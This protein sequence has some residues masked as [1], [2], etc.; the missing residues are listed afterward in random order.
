MSRIRVAVICDFI[1]EGWLS[2]D[3]IAEM[4]LRE[5]AAHHA[6]EIEATQVRPR[7]ARR[8][9]YGR[10]RALFN[11]D[12][13]CNR[14]F[15]YP[16]IVRRM[17]DDFDLFHVIDHSYAHLVS[18]L[19]PARAVVTCHDTDA[20]AVLRESAR[21]P[22]AP[23]LRAMARRTLAGMRQAAR[24]TCDSG[25]TRDA[26]TVA[27]LAPADRVT[28]VHNGVHPAFGPS[29]DPEA[30]AEAARLS[31]AAD[32]DATGDSIEVLHVG[33]TIARKRVDVVIRAIAELRT[34]FPRIRL[35]QAGGQFTREQQRMITGLGLARSTV[36]VPTM[37]VRVL[38][39]LYRR[40]AILAMPSESEGFGLPVA[41]AMAC[42]TPVLASDIAPLREVGGDAASYC[43]VGD[44]RAWALAISAMLRER[45]ESPASWE[46]RRQSGIDRA[47]QFTWHEFADRMAAIYRETAS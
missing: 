46:R 13:L 33:S 3:L 12:R 21:T 18:E 9:G 10:I 31:A 14:F 39:A 36:T 6:A 42:G 2:M 16:R 43:A 23:I 25:A 1:E 4:L 28:V 19:P 47:R 26:L 24:I 20:F 30:D 37:P 8:F 34:E 7:F 41:E 32:D 17:R 35:L 15:D 5:L 27:G 44:V 11:A 22:L 40:A 38:A 29:P 45:I